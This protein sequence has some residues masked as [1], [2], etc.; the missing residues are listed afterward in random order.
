MTSPPMAKVAQ[1]VR[2][3]L[4]RHAAPGPLARKDGIRLAACCAEVVGR[5]VL[6][7]KWR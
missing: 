6:D 3:G 2:P 1:S 4:V 7:R 5:R